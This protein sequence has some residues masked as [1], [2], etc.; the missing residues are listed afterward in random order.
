MEAKW[1][2]DFLSVARTGSF[3]RSAAERHVTQSAFSRRIKA[4]EQWVGVPLIDR[5]TYPTRLTPAGERFRDAAQEATASL[6]HTRQA[7]REAARADRP[8]LRIAIQHSLA[9]G[10]L[11]RWLATL[12]LAADDLLVQVRADNLHDCVRDLEEGA[13]DL[14]VCYTH[15]GL[16]LQ[17]DPGQYLALQLARDALV[18]VSCAGPDGRPRHAVRPGQTTPPVPWLAY[19]GDAFLGR[20]ASLALEAAEPALPL[21]AVLESSL[22]EALRAHAL[23]GLGVA[24]LPASVIADDLNAK[25]LLRAGPAT[26]DVPLR[27]KLYVDRELARGRLARLWRAAE[28]AANDGPA[29]AAADEL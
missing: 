27:V 23:A 6:Q 8:L 17:L 29:A 28:A 24:W 26:L 10:F 4:L 11:A 1:L 20:A 22:V 15:T 16:P 25:R 3:S 7:L 14:L 21:R 12:P 13:V 5:S 18:P 19:G 2:E 9:S